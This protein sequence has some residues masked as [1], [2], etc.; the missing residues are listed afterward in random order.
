MRITKTINEINK[1]SR[2]A[3]RKGKV[4]GLVPTM[5]FLHEGHLALVDIAKKKCDLVVVSIFVNPTQ[6]GPS[7]DLKK[8]PRSLS[9]DL[10]LLRARGVDLVFCPSA[11]EMYPAG[12]KTEV[13]VSDLTEKL[14]GISRPGHFA[15]VT[16]IV[17]KLFNAVMPDLA[18]F[19]EKDYQQQLIIKKMVYDLNRDV[20]IL[21]G[22][23]VR[24]ASGL[25]MSSRNRYLSVK[26]RELAT[27]LY[28]TLLL[29]RRLMRKGEKNQRRLRNKL[30]AA[31][32][33]NKIKLEYLEVLNAD[34]LEALTKLRGRILIALAARIAGTRLID[35]IVLNVGSG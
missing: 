17:L 28:Q 15:G 27:Q 10:K 14:C 23:T 30:V 9:R 26:D 22:K 33:S 25:A 31:L 5:G 8:Y 16:T 19:G 6:F 1:L 13:A 34:N 18:V 32:K 11:K 12:F 20:K 4:V 24:E 3:K 35:N 7:E 21:T 2:A 29:G